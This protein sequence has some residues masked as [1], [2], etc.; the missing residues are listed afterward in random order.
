MRGHMLAFIH[1]YL[2][3]VADAI[4][5]HAP[6]YE[7]LHERSIDNA[8]G[9]L[10]TASHLPNCCSRQIEEPAKPLDPLFE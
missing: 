4:V 3:I 8:I 6:A 1:D 5:D 9:L 7:A 2:P 10:P